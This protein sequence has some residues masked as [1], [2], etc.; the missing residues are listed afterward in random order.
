MV[1]SATQAGALPEGWRWARLGD[2]VT[3]VGSGLT[4]LGGQASYLPSGI[5]LIRSQNVHMNRF[6][7]SGLAYIS[8]EQDRLMSESRVQSGD[9]LLNI[10]GASIGRVC[11]VP[12]EI[13]PANVNQ[14]VSIIRSD[15]SF[16]PAFLAYYIASVDFQKHIFD[17][18]AGATRQALTKGLIEEFRIPLPPL[19]EQH[20]I[21]AILDEQMAAVE[22]ARAACEAQL[23]AARALPAAYLREVFESEEARRWP[24][25]PLGNVCEIVAQ[26]VDP[27]IP[28]YG[29]LPHVNGENIEGGTCRLKQVNTAAED[30]MTSSKYLFDAGDVLYSKLRPYL[31]KATV[32]D[33]RGLCSA[34]MYPIR[35]NRKMMDSWFAAWILISDEFT[36]YADEES[37]RA[38]MPK[39]NREQLFAWKCPLP[40]LSDQERIAMLLSTKVGDAE[41]LHTAL[42]S[43]LDAI[44]RLPAALLRRAF[45][46]EL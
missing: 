16:E 7:R 43:Q 6:V 45:A 26:Q 5:P 27:T 17:S 8:V 25:K 39:L 40:S 23:E 33:F 9:V 20:R 11:V 19:A 41:R 31:R 3:K 12:D 22:R 30:K 29:R 35:V 2:H 44:N 13:C 1:L 28:E 15:K 10:T 34:D 38:R 4:P 37:R 24:R 42:Q 36:K 14:H 46:G 32:V 18:Q 21:A